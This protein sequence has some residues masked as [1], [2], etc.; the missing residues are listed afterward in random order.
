MTYAHLSPKLVPVPVPRPDNR[1]TLPIPTPAASLA[2]AISIL[3]ARRPACPRR[4][5]TF[6]AFVVNLPSRAGWSW[7]IFWAETRPDAA[8]GLRMLGELT[9][10]NDGSYRCCVEL[11][12]AAGS[13]CT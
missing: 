8:H 6:P 4:L 11:P 2:R 1:A 13:Y 7:P 3:G 5:R 12:F 9:K 10:G